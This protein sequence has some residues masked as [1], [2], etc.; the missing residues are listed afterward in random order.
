MGANSAFL[1]NHG[2]GF[3]ITEGLTGVTKLEIAAGITSVDPDSNEETDESYY[4]D[5]GGAATVDVTGIQMSYSFEGHRDYNDDAQNYIYSLRDTTG[6]QR[7]T[8]FEVTEPDGTIISGPATI[9]EIK[10]PGGDANS[11][12][13]IEFTITYDGLP[14]VTPAPVTP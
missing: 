6:P 3:S 5:G 7:K 9:L 10:A 1:L 14:T 12:G 4:Y 13:E 2:Y 8:I 11:K